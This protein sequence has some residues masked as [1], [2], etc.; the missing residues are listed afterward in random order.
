[1]PEFT[2]VLVGLSAFFAGIFCGTAVVGPKIVSAVTGILG[3]M[4]HDLNP[5]RDVPMV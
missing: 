4:S 1:M 2:T 5:R 3:Q